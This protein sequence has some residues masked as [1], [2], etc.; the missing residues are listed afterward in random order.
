MCLGWR[1]DRS[2][3]IFSICSSSSS[4][5]R[6]HRTMRYVAVIIKSG[7]TTDTVTIIFQRAGVISET[8]DKATGLLLGCY[9]SFSEI[10]S[11][12]RL[13][14]F[15]HKWKIKSKKFSLCQKVQTNY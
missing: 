11:D 4:S 9:G 3:A 1:G 7:N 10:L 6:V 15:P 8:C 13:D 14:I 5:F 2:W 12:K